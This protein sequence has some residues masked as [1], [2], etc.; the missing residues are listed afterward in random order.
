MERLIDNQKTALQSLASAPQDDVEEKERLE[1]ALSFLEELL[2]FLTDVIGKLIIFNGLRY[3][4]L[5]VEL[6]NVY[7]IFM[8]FLLQY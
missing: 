4:R 7:D 3:I 8:V 6:L 1:E 5:S 2:V